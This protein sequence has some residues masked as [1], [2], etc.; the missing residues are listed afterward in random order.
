MHIHTHSRNHVKVYDD[1]DLSTVTLQSICLDLTFTQLF[2][3][4]QGPWWDSSWS[5]EGYA[6]W[7]TDRLWRWQSR[8]LSMW[9]VQCSSCGWG[10]CCPSQLGC[11]IQ[12]RHAFGDHLLRKPW[13]STSHEVFFWVPSKGGDEDQTRSSLCQSPQL[14]KQAPK[15]WTVN[16]VPLGIGT[17]CIFILFLLT[18]YL[19]W[20]GTHLSKKERKSPDI[21]LTF[22][23][24][25]LSFQF[26]FLLDFVGLTTFHACYLN[27]RVKVCFRYSS[28]KYL[29]S[30]RWNLEFVFE[31]NQVQH[32]LWITSKLVSWTCVFF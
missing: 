10:D 3:A 27:N 23:W 26:E 19:S 18:L 2:F 13:V 22:V 30:T 17:E 4:F 20:R 21:R 1:W 12:L 8:R 7:P 15:V 5:H 14:P 31:L 9:G 6:T 28:F 29:K 11:V 24:H 32:S 16:H 25:F